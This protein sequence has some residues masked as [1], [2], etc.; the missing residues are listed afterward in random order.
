MT[1]ADSSL[2]TADFAAISL[3][4]LHA[5]E[6]WEDSSNEWLPRRAIFELQIGPLLGFSRVWREVHIDLETGPEYLYRY[7]PFSCFVYVEDRAQ[8][9]VEFD[10][11]LERQRATVR[12]P[13][14]MAVTVTVVAELASAPATTGHGVDARE[15]ALRFCGVTLGE[16]AQPPQFM[17]TFPAQDLHV[18]SGDAQEPAPSP[19][20]VIG[21]YRSG[22]SVLTWALGQH[23]NIWPMEE[24]GWLAPLADAAI[25]GYRNAKTAARSFFDVY[26]LDR[27]RYVTEIGRAIDR[28]CRTASRVHLYGILLGRLS[29][30]AEHYN[31]EFQ[32][33][34]SAMNPK[35]RWVDGTPEHS[36]YVTVLR[37]IFPNARFIATV[38]DPLDVVSS[39]LRFER[40][41]GQAADIDAAAGMWIG[42]MRNVLLSYRAFGPD[43]IK[44]LRFE[45]L[46]DDAAQTLSD[47]FEFLGEPNFPKAAG[48]FSKRINSSN[49]SDA[50]RAA[51]R[52]EIDERPDLKTELLNLYAELCQAM[53]GPWERDS[54]AE[55]RLREIANNRITRISLE[56]RGGVPL[57]SE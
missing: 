3:K 13:V 38:R 25:L 37:A 7:F 5:R 28:L 12:V 40:A 45:S 56:Y 27:T 9:V 11:A 18:L 6:Y 55:S 48:T 43:V 41:G 49:V 30:Q 39:M 47:V 35:R 44:L 22:T 53:D 36:A 26:D 19:V 54:A 17:R 16:L 20:F 31:E 4:R 34:R 46:T 24:S 14:G 15:L 51:L 8:T 23:P 50:E 29:G 32:L 10:G 1:S 42:I 52:R 2:P 57:P 33:A 21:A